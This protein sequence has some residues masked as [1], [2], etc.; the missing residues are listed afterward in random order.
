MRIF[1]PSYKDKQTGETRHTDHYY[2]Y[3][4]GTRY[5]THI[6]DKRAAEAKARKMIS[7]LELG[8]DPRRYELAR[9]EDLTGLVQ[10]YAD[11]L[12]AGMPQQLQVAGRLNNVADGVKAKT[13]GEFT[14][15]K[16]VAWFKK[17]SMAR[18]TLS[19]YRVAI[20]SFGAW[21]VKAGHTPR[22]PFGGIE[23]IRHIEADRRRVRRALTADEFE[24]LLTT[25]AASLRRYCRLTG[26][27]RCMLYR[28]VAGTGLRRSE[29]A[30]LRPA[31]FKLDA[32]QPHVMVPAAYTKNRKVAIQPLP[33]ALV[34]LLREY[35][36]ALPDAP[37]WPVGNK[38]TGKMVKEDLEEAGIPLVV[39]GQVY[40]FHSLRGQFATR[41]ALAGVGLATAQKLMRHCTPALTANVYTHLGLD[42]LGA[43]VAN[44]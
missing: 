33:P 32:Q 19:H 28:L 42:D 9:D 29:V 20:R 22:N 37:V 13:L 4:R 18:R 41:L 21:L 23:P 17:S 31:S 10:Q 30:V 15:P 14:E 35:L 16:I 6:T 44:L 36:H 25:T 12:Q 40:D 8:Y 3:H 43:A 7:E 11:Q 26:P 24:L 39:A 2:F 34:P 38:I 5:P 27:Q 1:K